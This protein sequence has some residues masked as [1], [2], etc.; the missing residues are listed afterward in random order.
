MHIMRIT[1]AAPAEV[2]ARALTEFLYDLNMIYERLVILT[3]G[4][5]DESWYSSNFYRRRRRLD[6]PAKEL[7]VI[8][9]TRES[10]LLID[11][12]VDSLFAASLFLT[13]LVG[14]IKILREARLIEAKTRRVEAETEL[15]QAKT[16]LVQAKR[17]QVEAITKAI[18][19]LIFAEVNELKKGSGS[20]SEKTLFKPVKKDV[21]KLLDNPTIGIRNV[22]QITSEDK[23]K[24]GEG[25]GN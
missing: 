4:K 22:E 20:I 11:F 1:C 25:D 21:K 17:R 2:P 7:K 3:E 14:I 16:Q 9:I 8:R 5:V 13:V 19:E 23:P 15:V 12:V 6:E 18:T 24:H 10:P